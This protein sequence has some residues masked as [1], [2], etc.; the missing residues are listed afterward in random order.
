MSARAALVEAE[1]IKSVAN[2]DIDKEN[3]REL[4]KASKRQSILQKK[5]NRL[6]VK[7]GYGGLIAASLCTVVLFVRFSIKVGV[8]TYIHT[9][10]HTYIMVLM[11]YGHV[12]AMRHKWS[13]CRTID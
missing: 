12:S 6:T 5:L 2:E 1:H 13:R 4:K 11:S 10:I 8:Y 9:Y 3:K 7:I